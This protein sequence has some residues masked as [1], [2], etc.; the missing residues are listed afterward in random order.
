[1]NIKS[2]KL[3]QA[4]QTI[5]QTTIHSYVWFTGPYRRFRNSILFAVLA[6]T[7]R[8][9]G[10]M[11]GWAVKPSYRAVVLAK[12]FQWAIKGFSWYVLLFHSI[13]Q[14]IWLTVVALLTSEVVSVAVA[15]GEME[16]KDRGHLAS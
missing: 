16:M 4:M 11:R 8:N 5:Y 14:P 1:M 3:F 13:H 10:S 12:Y 9:G 2:S 15:A 6:L 7:V